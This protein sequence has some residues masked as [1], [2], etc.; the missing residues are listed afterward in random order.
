[1]IESKLGDYPISH[2]MV[3]ITDQGDRLVRVRPGAKDTPIRILD[4]GDGWVLIRGNWVPV[5]FYM[6]D[7]LYRLDLQGKLP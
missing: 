4:S 3:H 6:E 5:T 1:M 2:Y 7:I